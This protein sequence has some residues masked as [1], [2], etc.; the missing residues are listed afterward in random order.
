MRAAGRTPGRRTAFSIQHGP[1]HASPHVRRTFVS[2]SVFIGNRSPPRPA[3][4]HFFTIYRQCGMQPDNIF[5]LS[6]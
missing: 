4:F 5:S 6:F 2:L 3:L 1:H